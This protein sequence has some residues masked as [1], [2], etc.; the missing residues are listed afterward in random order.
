MSRPAWPTRDGRREGIPVVL[1]EAMAS[2]VPCVASRLSGIP[3]LVDDGMTGILTPP[4]D[5]VAIADALERLATDAS[6]RRGFGRASVEKVLRE[7]HLA[8]N[9]VALARRFPVQ[10]PTELHDATTGESR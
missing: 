8:D 2:G 7:F 9:T 1:M 10:P 3:E 5:A 4:R 6:L